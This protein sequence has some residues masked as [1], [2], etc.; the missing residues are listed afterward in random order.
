MPQGLRFPNAI[1]DFGRLDPIERE[2]GR[3]RDYIS[4]SVVQGSEVGSLLHDRWYSLAH[5]VVGIVVQTN[6]WDYS[7][8][9]ETFGVRPPAAVS[10]EERH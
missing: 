7:P 1:A 2:R 9:Y 3:H 4:T 6:P 8:L 10:G 5:A